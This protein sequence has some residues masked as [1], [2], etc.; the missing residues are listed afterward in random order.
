[1][2]NKTVMIMLTPLLTVILYQ[3]SSALKMDRD[4]TRETES[5]DSLFFFMEKTPCYGRCPVYKIFVYKSGYA[6][7]EATMN[8]EGKSGAYRT[9]ILKEEMKAISDKAMEIKYFS[10]N[11]EYNS[12]VTDLPSTKTSLNLN[13]KKKS[14]RNRHQGPRELREFEKF[15]EGIF[16]NQEWAEAVGK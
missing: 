15:A 8:V 13:G 12:P 14:I 1:M 2:T 11:D 7:L 10:L 9:T 16:M 3:C 5:G 4:K 6:V